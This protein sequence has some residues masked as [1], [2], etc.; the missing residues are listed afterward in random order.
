MKP[1]NL[2]ALALVTLLATPFQPSAQAQRRSPNSNGRNP[3]IAKIV[4]EIDAKKIERTIR[5]LV[6]FGTRNT[7]SE[8]N[9]PNR[10]IGAARDWLYSEFL[11]AAEASGGRMTVEKRSFEQPKV[12][13][14]PQPTVLT[15]VVATLKGTQPEAADR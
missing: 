13:R 1:I 9:D 14:I 4:R 2:L 5:Q 11:K 8:Q 6:S 7:L 15:N 10:G 3:V 12:D